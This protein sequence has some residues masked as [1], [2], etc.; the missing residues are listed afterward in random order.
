MP[1]WITTCICLCALAACK[2]PQSAGH[3]GDSPVERAPSSPPQTEATK[4]QENVDSSKLRSA[5]S[6]A[7]TD[8]LQRYY[9]ALAKRD[10][11]T[12]YALWSGHG[13]ASRKTFEEFQAGFAS[14]R[15]TR[16]TIDQPG[17]VEGAAG[18]LYISI[19]VSV[20]AELND[21]ETQ[22]FVGSYVLRRVNDVEGSS[23]EDRRWHIASASLHDAR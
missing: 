13:E 12:A 15:T 20:H 17:E 10:Y 1:A 2:S 3:V 8:V 4:P 6:A 9:A 19:P 21:G 14:T 16:I 11:K 22:S 5:E 18:S 23:A 7:A